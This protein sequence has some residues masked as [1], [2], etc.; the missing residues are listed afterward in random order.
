M[1]HLNK[2]R[3]IHADLKPDNLLISEDTKILKMCDFGTA[4][5]LEDNGIIKYIQSRF[6]RAPEVL[7]G[8]PPYNQ[9]DIWSIGVTLYEIYTQ[10][11]LFDGTTNNEMLKL[12]MDVRGKFNKKMLQSG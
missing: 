3:L 9:I 8:C 6:Y 4:L 10:K 5:T 7:L 11:Y 2:N 12:I 1:T